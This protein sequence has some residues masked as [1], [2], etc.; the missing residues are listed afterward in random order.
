LHDPQGE[1]RIVIA[2]S[3]LGMVVDLK[4]LHRVINYVPPNNIDSYVQALGRAGRDGTIPEA[5]LLFHGR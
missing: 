2:T 1:I 3:A 5:L 4:G